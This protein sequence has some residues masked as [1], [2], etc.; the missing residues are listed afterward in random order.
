[1]ATVKEIKSRLDAEGIPYDKG[2]K[3]AELEALLAD[4]LG[5]PTK[6]EQ[7]QNETCKLMQVTCPLLNLR[8]SP[9]MVTGNVAGILKQGET[10]R[11][12]EVTDGWASVLG[13]T[14]C[15]AEFLGEII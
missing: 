14:Y 10:V 2:A 5:T 6:A 12:Q 3:K 11:V 8:T 15:K 7:E 13:G 4:T 1:M 9:E